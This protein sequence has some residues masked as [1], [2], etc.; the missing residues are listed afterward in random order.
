MGY[1]CNNNIS[2][3]LAANIVLI[4][5]TN[6]DCGHGYSTW[7]LALK[8]NHWFYVKSCISC[9]GTVLGKYTLDLHFR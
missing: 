1:L 2:S 4:S 9:H 7:C 8:H 5:Y 6:S 3:A